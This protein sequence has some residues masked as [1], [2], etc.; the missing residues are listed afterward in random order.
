MAS[1]PSESRFLRADAILDAVLELPVHERPD[2]IAERCAGDRG[3]AELVERLLAH[4]EDDDPEL[5]PGGALAGGLGDALERDLGQRSGLEGQVVGRYRVVRELGRGGMA[6]VYLAERAENDFHQLVALKLLRPGLE[7]QH[8]VRRFHLE[9][10]ILAH[11]RHPNIAQLLDAGVSDDGRPYLAMEYVDGAPI[12]DF[13]DHRRLDVSQR[14]RLF[15]EAARAVDHAH[16]NLVVHR[17]I[18]PSNILVTDYGDVKLLDFGIA[19]L[20]EEDAQDVTRSHLRAMTPAYASP[21]QIE[22]GPITTS[23]DIYQ[24]GMLLYL[25]LTGRWPYPLASVSDAAV[26][27]AICREQPVRPSSAAGSRADG[28][29]V[30][31]GPPSTTAEI[32]YRRATSPPRLKRELAGDLD[33]IVLTA[34][35]KEPERRYLSVAQ[36]VG[37]V[38]RYLEGRTISARPDTVVYRVRT[39]VRRHTA[40]TATAAASLALVAGVVAFFTVELGIEQ[41]FAR[42]EAR[43]TGEAASFLAGLLQVAAPTRAKGEAVTARELLDRAAERIDSDLADQPELQ[44]AMMTVIGSVYGELAMFNEG[45]ALLERAVE[46][47][48]QHPGRRGL[49]LAT[50]LYALGEIGERTRDLDLARA[51]FSEALALREAA[52]GHRHPDVA[53]TL[54]ALGAVL[55]YDGDLDAARALHE[56]AIDV[57]AATVGPNDASYGVAL[58]RLASVL[59]EQRDDEASIPVFDQAI[60]V[61]EATSGRDH[62]ITA[63]AK[64]NYANALRQTGRKER[65]DA[66]YREVLPAL[67]SLYGRN[68]PVVA[69]VLNSHSNLLR[70]MG[71]LD[72]A[73]AALQRALAIWSSSLGPHHPQVGWA[74]NNLGLVER[75]RGNHAAA[76]DYFLRSVEIAEAANGPDHPDVATQLANLAGELHSLGDTE[77]AIPL[78]ERA[79]AIR[80]RV[81]GTNHAHVGEAVGE[82][83]ELYFALGRHTAAEPLF[84][85]AAELGR[86][87]PQDRP[88]AVTAPRIGQARCLA[89]MGRTAEAAALLLAEREFCD[90][91]SR[92]MVEQALAEIDGGRAAPPPT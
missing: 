51:S 12:D 22:G 60:A 45:R 34:L 52:L 48:R 6:V 36:L 37:D 92:T 26:L 31:G 43:K 81:Y 24:L 1:S 84:R 17:D 5:A 68:H 18:K 85:R 11:A 14:L 54:D 39:F 86:D 8:V 65:A 70:S 10:Q 80:E 2:A 63:A 67:E 91:G 28:E 50:S 89:A 79:I 78:L 16:R 73:E 3:L 61:L 62:P 56:E 25:L 20:L 64:F 42:M 44:A 72:Q 49:D 66:I 40:A 41:N 38:E 90:A 59:Q 23:T 55:R 32:A 87:Q 76:R 57:L 35:R 46:I 4:C 47:R 15:L 71:R 75:D 27:L 29:P 30:P 77:G 19:K 21:E 74:L 88:H 83:A 33:T 9:R 58:N 69:T 53:R 82:L 7:S 13:C